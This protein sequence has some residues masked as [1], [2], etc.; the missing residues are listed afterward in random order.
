MPS[1]QQVYCSACEIKHSRPVGRN[2]RKGSNVTP[3]AFSVEPTAVPSTSTANVNPIA[4]QP[5]LDLSAEIL[6]QLTNVSDQLSALDS[7]VRSNEKALAD[8]TATQTA[9]VLPANPLA[10]GTSVAP[11]RDVGPS[12]GASASYVV[13]NPDKAV[14]PSVD[15]IRTNPRVQDQVDHRVSDLRQLN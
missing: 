15:F 5:P 1:K 11:V 10:S 7:R 6:K 12:V 8:Q 2:C 4:T 9:A 3:T 14:V 13:L